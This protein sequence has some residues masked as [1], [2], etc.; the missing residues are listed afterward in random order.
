V[1][2]EWPF[3]LKGDPKGQ[4]QEPKQPKLYTSLLIINELGGE[5]ALL[6]TIPLSTSAT[7]E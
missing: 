2:P 1:Y 3:E 5:K 4:C 6:G 7:V